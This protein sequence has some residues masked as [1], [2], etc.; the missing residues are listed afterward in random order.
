MK[1]EDYIFKSRALKGLDLSEGRGDG[2]FLLLDGWDEL[3]INH[4]EEDSFFLDLLTGQV[5]PQETTSHHASEVLIS[6]CGHRIYQYIEV[7]GFTE[8]N[9]HTFLKSNASEV[10]EDLMTY[11]TSHPHIKS[12]MH[13]PLNAAILVK[14]Y[15]QAKQGRKFFHRLSSMTHSSCS[16]I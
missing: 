4:R 10:L 15:I 13:N 1:S 3:P 9:V 5:L 7:T 11:I 14:V 8:E 12:M 2:V 16:A 6:E